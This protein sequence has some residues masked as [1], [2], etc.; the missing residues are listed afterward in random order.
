MENLKLETF[1][2]SEQDWEINQYKVLG[3][4]KEFQTEFNKKKIYPA[5]SELIAL[6]T[7]LQEILDNEANLNGKFPKQI[8][9]YD[10]KNKKLIFETIE[11]IND[12]EKFLF[13]LIEWA[14]P[15][16]KNAIEEAAVLFEFVEK[17]IEIEEVG[18]L[19][20]YKDEGYIIIPDN[21]NRKLMVHRFE[22]TLFSSNSE[23]YRTLKTT[24]IEEIQKAVIEKSPES[25]KLELIKKFSDLPNPATYF[26]ETELDF[27]FTET[28]FPIAK[29][30]LM[31]KVAAA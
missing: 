15:L 8:V 30:K 31:A 21:T 6:S 20:L 18:I 22:C 28:I 16:I 3:G 14:L 19:P 13:G 24:F 1:L 11:K 12:K 29:R 27:P 4:I 9:N 2:S 17:N 7:V 10:F 23:K 26:C 5:L 25:I